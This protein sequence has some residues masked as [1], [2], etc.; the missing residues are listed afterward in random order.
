MVVG[1]GQIAVGKIR[2]LLEAGA[3]VTVIAPDA[4]PYIVELAVEGRLTLVPREY[5]P[6]DLEGAFLVIA[7][8]DDLTVNRSVFREAE[9]LNIPCNVVDQPELCSFIAPSIVRKGVIAVAI[10]TGGTS[11]ALAK[12]LKEKV[13]SLLP[14]TLGE[15]AELLGELRPLAKELMA[16]PEAR[17]RAWQRVVESDAYEI[18]LA[19][20]REEAKAR[21]RAILMEEAACT[22]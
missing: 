7:A 1:G 16:D 18:M 11:P 17:N 13:A 2:G 14:D 19:K 5:R 15:F 22:S 20:G 8:T 3:V 9:E 12:R 10:S 21:I 6:G 4:D